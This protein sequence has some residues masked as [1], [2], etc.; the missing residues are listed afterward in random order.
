MHLRDLEQNLYALQGFSSKAM[1]VA[2]VCE[3]RAT[4]YL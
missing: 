1:I 4:E 2:T 3:E